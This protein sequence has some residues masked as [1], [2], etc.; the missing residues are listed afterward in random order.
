MGPRL[1]LLLLAFFVSYQAQT[2]EACKKRFDTYLNFNGSL[3]KRVLFGEHHISIF[4]EKGE[5]EFTAFEHELS[6]LAEMFD[7]ASEADLIRFYKKKANNKLS[8][9]QRDSI[10]IHSESSSYPVLKNNSLKGI[11]IAIDPGHIAGTF[12]EAMNEQKFLYFVKDSIHHPTDSIKLYESELTFKTA[13]IL[14]NM[15]EARGAEVFLTREKQGYTSFGMSYAAW[16]NTQKL[17]VLDSLLFKKEI[18]IKEHRHFLKLESYP[19]FWEF[20]RDYELKNRAR[21]INGFK[22]HASVII[23]YNVDEKNNPWKKTSNQNYT[24]AFIGG[25]FTANRLDNAP[26]KMNFLRLLF[27]K[28]LE[29]SEKLSMLSIAQFNENLKIPIACNADADYLQNNCL[30][31]SNHGVY[32]RQLALCNSIRSP[33]VYGES[34]YQDNE[35]ECKRLMDNSIVCEGVKTNERVKQVAL[36]YYNALLSYF[37]K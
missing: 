7:S 37:G 36:S 6:V 28:Q 24:M 26:S 19:F 21:I 15:L 30:T 35:E 34:L 16:F 31:L 25:A 2:V 3:N 10:R 27:T 11:R 29:E 23:H 32:S 20:F 13:L 33:L 4:S 22:P 17:R 9:R 12:S 18:T 1:I 8:K 5:K 14:K